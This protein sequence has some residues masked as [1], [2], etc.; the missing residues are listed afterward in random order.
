MDPLSKSLSF[1]FVVTT[2]LGI[3]LQV[4]HGEMLS[5]LRHYRLMAK[6]LAANFVLVP[7]LGLL[8]AHT[9]PLGKGATVAIIMLAAAPG[10]LN[11]LQFT[12]KARGAMSFAVAILFTL[13]VLAVLVSPAL[14]AA[15]LRAETPLI[16]PYA[17]LVTV[18]VLLILAPLVAGR[19][20]R[21]VLASKAQPV[22]TAM[23]IV[24]M[25]SFVAVVLLLMAQRKQAM[26]ALTRSELA[27]MLLLIAGSM[28]IGWLMG[29]PETGT[30]RVLVTNTSMRNAA[31]CYIIA[32]RSF[33][34]S[35]VDVAVVAFS[36]LMI[37]PNM[38]FTLYSIVRA[39]KRH[40]PSG[41]VG[42]VKA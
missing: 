14:M 31:L 9:M 7:A 6:S 40:E 8:L 34:A 33:P 12:S 24:G 16:L 35:D 37:P 18:L 21:P 36:A 26:A 17:R 42:D 4:S 11:A 25:L 19:V 10:G 20:L 2:M 28:V 30:R 3:G 41:T 15:M 32:T 13:S 23:G 38:L 22:A 5:A 39:R 1:L 29:G 27:S